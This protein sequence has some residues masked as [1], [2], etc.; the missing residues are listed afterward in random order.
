VFTFVRH[1]DTWFQKDYI[2]AFNTDEGDQFGSSVA[3]SG[4]TLAVGAPFEDSN[5]RGINTGGEADN[6]APDAG[7]VYVFTHD[8]SGWTQQAYIKASNSLSDDKFGWSVAL[9]GEVLAVGAKT[10]NSTNGNSGAAYV[11]IESSGTWSEQKYLTAF[12]ADPNDWF[13]YSIALEGGTLAV[14]AN[15]E[16]S[17]LSGIDQNP[18]DN[19]A[20]DSGAVYVFQ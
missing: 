4:D 17:G 12:N 3:L 11:F 14:G 15:Q 16:A 8:S 6:Q 7:A 5:A 19:S 10:S 1:G 18:F 9:D 20:P 2:K 13:G